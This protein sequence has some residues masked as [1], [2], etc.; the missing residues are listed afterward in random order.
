MP[1]LGWLRVVALATLLAPPVSA[2]LLGID[3]GGQYFKAS[4][5]APGKPFEVVHNQHSKRKTPTAVSFHDT[6]RTFGDDALASASRGVKKTPMFFASQ[7]GP[8][9]SK[10]HWLPSRFY[11]YD[12][13][14]NDSGSLR[15]E[16]GG[17]A[18]TVEEVTGHLLGFAKGL[19][20]EAVD[21][22]S[23]SDTI[24]TIPADATFLRRRSLLTAAKMARLPRPQLIHE[25][26]AA[27]LQRALDL[28]LSGSNG[29]NNEST[30]L[31]YN[32]GAR[33]VEACLVHYRGAKHREKNTVAMEMLGCGSSDQLGGH[34]V[35]LVVAERMLKAFQEKHPKL[36]EGILTSTRAL[37][38][39]EKEAMG[40]KHVL[41]A[42][43]EA[44]FRVESLYEDTDFTQQVKR[45]TFEDWCSG[46]FASVSKPID[47]ALQVA[48]LSPADIDEVELI[49]GGWRIPRIQK[50]LSEY[51]YSSRGPSLPALNLSQHLNGDEAMAQ[52]A[53]FFGANSSV[54][55]RTKTIFFTDS[56]PHGYN[57]TLT[58]LTPSQP[59][60]EGWTRSVELFV[61]RSPLRSRK[62]VKLNLG[63]DLRATLLENSVE[64]V[65]WDI[66]GI[67]NATLANAGLGTPLISL[68]FELDGSGIVQIASVT[69]IFDEPVPVEEPKKADTNASASNASAGDANASADAAEPAEAETSAV[70]ENVSNGSNTSAAN[71]VKIRKKKVGIPP[72]ESF[73][74]LAARPVT[75]DEVRHAI[76][77][78]ST[79]DA[80]D[81]EV[82]KIG[83]AKNALESFV[84]DSREKLSNDEGGVQQV[85]TEESRAEIME[86]LVAMEDWL[87][88][89]EARNANASLLEDKLRVL[90]EQVHP[91][92]RRAMELEYRGQLPELVK[93]VEE[94]VNQTL[95]YVRKNMTWVDPKEIEGVA[96]LSAAFD[97]WFAN[98]TEQQEKQAL[99]EEP[100][101]Y[102]RDAKL[103]LQRMQ[104]EAQ[105]LLKIRKIDPMPYSNDKGQYGGGY[106]ER[107]RSFYE[108]MYKNFST[109]GTNGSDWWRNFSNFSNFQGWNNS[110]YMRSFYEQSARNFS[111]EGAIN[112]SDNSSKPGEAGGSGEDAETDGGKTEL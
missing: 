75:E 1:L 80:A 19:A 10:L 76:E 79:M 106:D 5:V 45:E 42:N 12:L 4:V 8:V 53:C 93:K 30:V 61:P 26:S 48:E 21:G 92:L 3:L 63:F 47:D 7:L 66:A 13:G 2:F 60:E 50:L 51:L 43:K 102:T 49:G 71:S 20:M 67:H 86:K 27:A 36:A 94:F 9:S 98:V 37:K 70:V 16:F 41:S 100:A 39:L 108:N 64:V 57:L 90:Q 91:I 25:T 62:T 33:H 68:K 44:Q 34:L 77:R 88:E 73:G 74:G 29:T 38:K 69:T 111:S 56:T 107:M 81:A 28:D 84:Y 65:H 99:T 101:Y 24:L 96:S 112:S 83:A 97:A 72:M 103:R 17:E 85:S 23:V 58:P 14:V 89:D 22:I 35:D 95:S 40:M 55:F 109:N 11:P 82:R 32:M 54:S 18:Y 87:Y 78:L 46:I 104:S 110:E 6:M 105:R 15:F 31:Y 52:G 59:H